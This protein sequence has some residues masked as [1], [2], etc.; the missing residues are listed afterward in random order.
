MNAL[1]QEL[2]AAQSVKRCRLL[3]VMN[4]FGGDIEHVRKF[5]E[6]LNERRNDIDNP[7]AVDRHQRREELK[8][9]YASQLAELSSAGIH[10][11]NPG[12]MRQLEKH[13][14]DVNQVGV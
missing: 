3:R 6:K 11:N 5:L 13:Q 4:H 12:I 10:V 14:G 7:R 9:K 2:P 1:Q 8:T